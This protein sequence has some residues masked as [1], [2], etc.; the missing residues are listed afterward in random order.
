MA[1]TKRHFTPRVSG[2][3]PRATGRGGGRLFQEFLELFL[4]GGLVFAALAGLWLLWAITLRAKVELAVGAFLPQ[5]GL[6]W[7]APLLWFVAFLRALRRTPLQVLRRWNL[8]LGSLL[9]VVVLVGVLSFVTFEFL[10]LKRLWI[11]NVGGEAWGGAVAGASPGSAAIRLGGLAVAGAALLFPRRAW[12]VAR[13]VWSWSAGGAGFVV[14]RAPRWWRTALGKGAQLRGKGRPLSPG[15]E[16]PVAGAGPLEKLGKLGRLRK[17]KPPQ[18]L[19]VAAPEKVVVPLRPSGYQGLPPAYL[20]RRAAESPVSRDVLRAQADR[21]EA[22]LAQYGIEV[23]VRDIR[24]G[25]T[26]TLYGLVPGW[27]RRAGQVK[28]R[29]PERRVTVDAI[30][31]RE[32]DLAMALAAPSLR[33]EAPVPGESL[34]GVEVPN[35]AASLVALGSVMDSREFRQ[36]R[37]TAALPIALGKGSGGDVVAADL[38]QMPHLLVAGATGS[39]KSVLIHGL[40]ASLLMQFSPW[41]VRLLLVDPKRV[42]LTHYKGIPHLVTPVVVEPDQAVKVL[43]GAVMEMTHRL[44][45]LEEQGAR[46]ISAYNQKVTDPLERMPYLVVIVDEVADLMMA[47][48]NDIEHAL[49]RLAQLGR[50]TG[51]HLVVATQ[52]PSVDVITGLIKANFPSRMSFAL[53]S[54]I[55]SRTILDTP[56]AEKLM[57]RGD[58]LFLPQDLPKPR[59]VQGAFVSD[60]EIRSLVEFWRDH[61]GPLPPAIDLEPRGRDAELADDLAAGG[62]D[63]LMEKAT[64]LAQRYTHVSTSLLQRRLRIGY[65]RA[66]RLRE[67]MEA[68]GVVALDGEVLHRD[69]GA[70]EEE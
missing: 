70:A 53:S 3:A 56:G 13:T 57:G 25:P 51:I 48:S 46:N 32:K 34:V 52:R 58:M 26:V 55:D 14:A 10:A 2:S 60:E 18:A 9:L 64:E 1:R 31:A 4:L 6:G 42:E 17:V 24:P 39:G 38:A 8:W 45:L 66:A 28:G 54:Q 30:L 65:P 47:A 19:A 7:V 16:Q 5:V 20:L 40:V 62:Q 43:R 12:S 67:E 29:D 33:F 59:R 36:L 44:R 15:G 22:A 11:L 50:A 61:A 35:P 23:T 21:I 49:C 69:A 41:D 63:E 68:A 27:V 37:T